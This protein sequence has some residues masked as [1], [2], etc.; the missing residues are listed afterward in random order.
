[1]TSD[2]RPLDPP[3]PEHQQPPEPTAATYTAF[4][5]TRTLARGLLEP[6]IRTTK[7]CLDAEPELRVV[8]LDDATSRQVDFDFDGSEDEVVERAVAM[9]A[10]TTAAAQSSRRGMVSREVALLPR[11]WE[12]LSRQPESVS[13]ALRRLI[14]EAD[15]SDAGRAP[16][17]RAITG[18]LM[19]AMARDLPDGEQT[20]RA[21]LD[22]DVTAFRELARRLPRELRDHL[23]VLLRDGEPPVPPQ[24]G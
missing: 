15:A 20:S 5:G 21:L 24:T 19:W 22:A 23:E 14:D 11:H 8:I 17:A 7:Q 1:M 18:R 4:A 16:T 13:A 6:V 12:W 2:L 9:V 10:H 3:Q